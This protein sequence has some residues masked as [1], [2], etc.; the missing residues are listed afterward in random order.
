MS[1]KFYLS[2]FAVVLLSLQPLFS[3]SLGYSGGL[4]AGN[5]ID[6]YLMGGASCASPTVSST[7]SWSVSPAPSSISYI[8]TGGNYLRIRA[9]W[10]SAASATITVSYGC[11]SGS[12]GSQMLSLNI[13]NRVTPSVSL[14]LSLNNSN[15]CLNNALT[16][17]ATP[18]NGGSSPTYAF[19]IDGQQVSSGLSTTYSTTS[20]A[21]GAHSVYVVMWS[22]LTCTTAPNAT[23][24]TQNFSVVTAQDGAIQTNSNR[25]CIGQS[26]VISSSGG[27]G[28]PYYWCSSNG[29]IT[30]NIF[31]ESY[32]GQTSFSHTP[33]APGTYRYMLRN[34][35][36][37]GYCYGTCPPS[38]YVDVIVD[39]PA[40]PGLISGPS[41]VT[42]GKQYAYSLLNPSYSESFVWNITNGE[43]ISGQGSLTINAKFYSGGG[44]LSVT[45]SNALCGQGST[46]SLLVKDGLNYI[47]EESVLIPNVT[48][49]SGV[50]QLSENERNKTTAYFDGLGRTVQTVKWRNSNTHK[51]LVIIEEYD[52]FGR[53]SK[54]YLEYSSDET[55]GFFKSSAVAD[56][57]AFYDPA[58]NTVAIAKDIA[59]YQVSLFEPSPLN[60]VLK[61]GAPGQAWQPD[62]DPYSIL[63]K[64]I[65]QRFEL[66]Q[67][68]DV[69]FW[70]YDY[71]THR[72]SAKNGTN[73]VY[74][75]SSELSISRT[76]DENNRSVIEYT[77]KLGKTVLKR[78]Q[79]GDSPVTYTSTYYIYDDFG[80]LR[81]VL[82][83]EASA[84]LDTEYHNATTTNQDGFL[85]R[86]AFRYKYDSRK[87]MIEKQ[88]PGASPVYLVYDNRDRLVLTQDGNQRTPKYWSFTKYDAF[89][90]P[91]LTGIYTCDSTLV[92]GKMQR[93]IDLFYANLPSNGGAW[94]ESYIGAATGNVHG[95]DNKSYPIVTDPYACLSSTY[96]DN[97]SIKAGWGSNYNYVNDA[98]TSVTN[99]ITYNQPSAEFAWVRGLVTASKVK[100]LDGGTTGGYTWLKA[101]SYYDDQRHVIQTITENLK[102]GED[103]V[104]NLY[105]FTGKILKTKT[106]HIE[107]DVTWKDQVGT[108]I[109]GNKLTRSSVA[110]AGVASQQQLAAGQDGWV[111]FIVSEINT[112]RYLGLNDTNPDVNGTNIDYSFKLTSATL[113]V[114]EN[115]VTKATV[116]GIKS[117]DVLRIE[118][119]G[120]A[121]KYYRNGGQITLSPASTAS[122]SLLMVDVS[123][124]T[125]NSTLVGVKTSFSTTSK[126]VSRTLEYDHAGRLLKT[127]HQIDAEPEVFLTTNK[128]NELG[129]LVDKKLHSTNSNATDAKQS[130]DYRYNIRGWLTKMNESDI[131]TGFNDPSNAGEARDLFGMELGYNADIGTG[132]S[133]LFNGNISAMKW[134]NNLG[135]G[136]SKEKAYNYSYDALNR[137]TA[138]SFKENTTSWN[139]AANSGYSE[140]GYSYDLNGN[141]MGLLRYDKRGSTAAVDNLVYNYG[142]GATLSNKLL[143]VSDTGDKF[144]GFIDG[145]NTG[146]DY[147]Y[148]VNGNMITDQNKGITTAITYNFMNLPE[149]VTRGGTGGNIV[150]Y[151]YDAGGRKLSQVATFSGAQKQTDYVGEFQYEND[152]LQF[153]SHE[154]GRAVVSGSQVIY[155]NAGDNVTD[156]NA[157]NTT[158]TTLKQN[159]NET[160]VKA[161]SNGT[162]VRTGMFPIGNTYPVQPGER[163]R[164]RAKGYRDKGTAASSSQAYILV[165]TNGADLGWPGAALPVSLTTAQTESW[166]EQIITVP[167]G[168][169]TLQAGVVWNT[170]LAG[171]VIYLNEFE[172]TKLTTNTTPEYQY[173][174]KDHLGNVH[175]TF[176][177]KTLTATNYTAGFET[178][179]QATEQSNFSNYQTSHINTVPSN[180]TTGANSYKLDGGY[181]GQ[182]GTTKTFSVMPGDFV[183][184]QG[185]A[186]Y[187]TPS[188]TPTNYT[189]FV[190]S[191]LT[192]FNL[193]APAP[194]ETGTAASGVN[195]FGNWEI[196]PSGDDSK[197]DPMKI[198]VTIIL[199]DRNYN[200]IDVS[201]QAV[202]S[203]GELASAN[204][205]V[206]EPGYAY[207]YISNEHP[208]QTDVY[209]DDVTVTYTPSPV[210]QMDNYYPFGLAFNSYSRE[211]SINQKYLYNGKEIQDEL[212]LGWL[213]F[214]AR[215]Y[216]PAIA[217]WMTVDPLA[218]QM[219]R[220]SPYNYA[221]DNPIR[222]IDPDGMAPG[223]YFTQQ[224]EY[225]GSDGIDDKKVYEVA[226]VA[227]VSSNS[228][229]NIV[230]NQGEL[231]GPEEIGVRDDFLDMN[232]YEITS[233]ETKNNLIG[234]SINMKNEGTTDD[235]ATITVTGGDR[236]GASNA[237]VSGATGSRH[238]FGDA[239]DITVAGM[240]NKDLTTAADASGLFSK[241]IYYPNWGN[242]GGFATHA[243]QGV[244]AA[245]KPTTTQVLNFQ[246]NGPHCHVDNGPSKLYA[247]EYTGHTSTTNPGSGTYK[248][249]N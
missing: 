134:S 143:K 219:R 215:M 84:R 226:N 208:Y 126:S 75:S 222:Y 228:E 40:N 70:V 31:S 124:A 187:G 178:A 153:I 237:G 216:D 150:R 181:V 214:G 80:N 101:I 146:N 156:F 58:G 139:A 113:T 243:V 15:V 123:F 141:I 213:D 7:T 242:T 157:S 51:D 11:S 116:A 176:T 3:Q 172:I 175:L 128:Y 238:T 130:V 132:N 83:P 197:N 17:T 97:Y 182:V 6:V 42:P 236:D 88:V 245:G 158:L 149:L 34:Q 95:Y 183:Q 103:R 19:Y 29:G 112:T 93:R 119:T 220:F 64:S 71:P 209:F 234:L 171:E 67:G 154:E 47:I 27:I 22:S 35:N 53:N 162:V 114:V 190:A 127:R 186:K 10:T 59:P 151:I 195:T 66:N 48:N 30:W 38:P 193:S 9:T 14:S 96:Y 201:Y 73:L 44:T 138:A 117:G 152:A 224:G 109:V 168:A 212:N 225:L 33:P 26:I 179:N 232:G 249:L 189:N 167:V 192:A 133:Q 120:T 147:T 36:S 24:S 188:G 131:Q 155:S 41:L 16:L 28:T 39:G 105:D 196:G 137:I 217:R 76:I 191:L 49:A 89:N 77:E 204:Y 122:S 247:Q 61:K 107:R 32:A 235:Y 185:Y 52:Q 166:I 210:I 8:Q 92:Q 37:C 144:A 62:S 174:L 4:C 20:L 104:S 173:N 86:W 72:I 65:K 160:Y 136:T 57:S 68:T 177:A 82:P 163:Y 223:D 45:T 248:K 54:N 165:Q 164:I 23:S 239:A 159:G 198:F 94:Y 206:K 246:S 56:Q 218:D 25:I 241:S 90:R 60:R 91:V 78:V 121:V 43:I 233:D 200:F 135:L 118:R 98:F 108:L 69:L 87:R 203:S 205:T 18:I 230:V 125:N 99:G 55:N 106:T 79:A 21:L 211:N 145:T 240:T 244:D 74:Y 110:T 207:L 229:G 111:E 180:A 1:R 221:F 161:I 50:D 2:T 169:T 85:S 102:G 184:I 115:N 63:D 194:G 12:A 148:D 227:S 46:S 231:G 129:Q 202:T 142:A 140:S 5:S 81:V 100:V 13:L 170:V 199:F